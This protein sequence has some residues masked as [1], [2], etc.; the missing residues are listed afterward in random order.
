[1]M[2][3]LIQLD[4]DI[5]L[6]ING[7]N[8][9]SFDAIMWWVSGKTTWWPFYTLLLVYFGW[10]KGWQLAPMLLFIIIAITLTD[11]T[12]VH[13]FKNV[14]QRLRPCHEPALEDLVHVPT[15]A[16]VD[17]IGGPDAA[18]AQEIDRGHGQAPMA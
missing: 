8:N 7:L 9:A 13:L 12:S 16:N 5:F 11:Q 17:E 2:E 14:F 6:F 18:R 1:M 15:L 3:W 10:K 4:R